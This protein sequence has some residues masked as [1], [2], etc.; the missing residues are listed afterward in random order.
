MAKQRLVDEISNI[1]SSLHDVCWFYSGV[2][3]NRLIKA[4]MKDYSRFFSKVVT[5]TTRKPR[6]DEVNGTN[7]HYISL[8]QFHS[9]QSQSKYFVE[10]ALVHNNMYGLSYTA[11]AEVSRQNKISIFEIDIQ[12]AQSIKALEN[13]LRIKPFYLF[14]APPNITKLHDR[15]LER[16]SETP[17]EIALRL[18]NAEIEIDAARNSDIFNATIINDDLNN[19]T[20]A[21]FRLVR[22]W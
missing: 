11:W 16:G 5:H 3:K 22:D 6:P 9:L 17:E 10:T 18:R 20:A 1:I 21:F 2:G 7:Y 19:A 13:K 12:G 15:L 14:I 8:E 4:L